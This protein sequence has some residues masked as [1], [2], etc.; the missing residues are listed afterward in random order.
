MKFV[1]VALVIGNGSYNWVVGA[2][3][4][5]AIVVGGALALDFKGTATVFTSRRARFGALG[6]PLWFW[7]AWGAFVV[8][9][10]VVAV[11]Q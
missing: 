8:L 1:S 6:G 7:R 2:A 9:C 4:L 11:V 3:G 10:G 5:L